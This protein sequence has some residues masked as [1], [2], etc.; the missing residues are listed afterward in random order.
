MLKETDN[1]IPKMEKTTVSVGWNP[2]FFHWGLW[3]HPLLHQMFIFCGVGVKVTSWNPWLVSIPRTRRLSVRTI[4]KAILYRSEQNKRQEKLN[5]VLQGASIVCASSYIP[6]TEQM[7]RSFET[8]AS[9]KNRRT[10]I[11]LLNPLHEMHW[12]SLAENGQ[13]IGKVS[14]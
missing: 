6:P 2:F 7:L 1:D 8:A 4:L 11:V 13:K 5:S 10:G 3:R 9:G 12:W 14:Q